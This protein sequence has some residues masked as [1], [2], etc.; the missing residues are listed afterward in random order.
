MRDLFM[1]TSK[2]SYLR[3]SALRIACLPRF[4]TIRGC[5]QKMLPYLSM[6]GCVN[7]FCSY[8]VLAKTLIF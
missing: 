4:V 3:A 8:L 7:I 1:G 5:S 2:N 6:T